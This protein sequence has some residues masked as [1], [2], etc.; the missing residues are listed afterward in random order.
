MRRSRRRQ[1]FAILHLDFDS[2]DDEIF[3][4]RLNTVG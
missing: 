1:D 3:L 4:F 2:L